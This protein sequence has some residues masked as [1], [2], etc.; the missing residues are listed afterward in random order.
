VQALYFGSAWTKVPAVA[1]QRVAL[2]GFLS[3]LVGSPFMDT[4]S[5]AGYDVG[6]GT[7]L[8]GG[9][10]HRALPT[11]AF[12]T[13]DDIRRGLKTD[14]RNG[15][16]AAP[17]PNR[18][19]VVFVQ[20]DVIA[21]L[22]GGVTTQNGL[23]GWHDFFVRPDGATVFYAVVAYPRGLV[24]NSSQVARPAND[25]TVVASHELAEAVTD[26]VFNGWLDFVFRGSTLEIDEIGDTAQIDRAAAPVQQLGNYLV[27]DFIGQDNVIQN[28][29]TA[30]SNLISS[31]TVLSVSPTAFT[32]QVQG[33][34]G[35]I[36]PTGNVTLLVDNTIVGS[37]QPL[38]P[39]NGV[40]TASFPRGMAPGVHTVLAIYAGDGQYLASASATV[41]VNVA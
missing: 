29:A 7:F 22:P 37:A 8:P 3:T 35:T 27:Q 39:M 4:L 18:L 11:G 6:R 34:G 24:H 20:P 17:D 25:L 28:P 32:V 36:Q 40:M 41:V 9:V 26:P 33:A 2:E 12:I 23:L 14:L 1:R 13:N 19:Y 38:A 5:R 31:S 16:L 10:D 30:T 21:R 15:T